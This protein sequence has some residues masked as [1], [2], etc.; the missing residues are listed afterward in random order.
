MKS[1]LILT[2]A[3]LVGGA[4]STFAQ[5]H[6]EGEEYYKADQLN[7]AYELLQRNMN[8]PGTDKAVSNY[9]LGLISLRAK[10]LDDAKK[11]FE[12]GIADN[13]NYGYNYVGLGQ[14][15]LMNGDKKAAEQYFKDAK[16]NSKKDASL[17]IAIARAYYNVDPVA[18]AKEIEKNIDQ[19]RKDSPKDGLAATNTDI[20]LFEGDILNDKQDWGGAANKYEMATTYNKNATEAYVKYANLFTQVNQDYAI[21][22][23][24][25]LLQVNPQSALGQRELANAYYNKGDFKNAAN[26]YAKYVQNPNHF[27]QD[28]DRYAFLLFYGQDYK[29]GYDY[30]SKLF[31]ENP[32]NF[33]AQRYQFMNAA[34]LP[35]M[36]DNLL[37]MAEAL[38]TAHKS[39]SNNKFAPIDYILIGE[40]LNKANRPDEVKALFEEAIADTPDNPEYYRQLGSAYINEKDYAKGAD[41]YLQAVE[42]AATPGFNDIMQAA[43]YSYLAG[44]NLKATDAQTGTKYL[45]QAT[46]LAEKAKGVAPKDPRP[47]KLLG[48]I[49]IQTVPDSQVTTVAAPFYLQAVEMIDNSPNPASFANYSKSLYNY[50]GNYYLDQKDNGAA[51]MYFQK[52]LELDPT[53]ESVKKVLNSL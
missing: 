45:N 44:A 19:A 52:L 18:Y 7:N 39:N 46:T 20:Y 22:M 1:K 9:Y 23:L 17:S 2:A 24:N 15:S 42:V 43:N 33:T 53:N 29:G 25:K 31:K 12:Q 50:L 14:L 26:A 38:Y 51:K 10:K 3:I 36:Q 30:A 16:K 6:L 32:S 34:Q 11:Y 5:T 47:Y 37:P 49:S 41:L 8:N 21:N 13:P 40:E 27:K 28:E 48:D 4:F 35:E